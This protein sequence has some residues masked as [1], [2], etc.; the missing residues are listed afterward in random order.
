MSVHPSIRSPYRARV[1][2]T[3]GRYPGGPGPLG[4]RRRTRPGRAER[5]AET[6]EWAAASGGVPG[7]PPRAEP[8]RCGAARGGQGRGWASKQWALRAR[9]RKA[10]A[11]AQA[12]AGLGWAE[13][14]GSW[15]DDSGAAPARPPGARPTP[16]SP[17]SQ[18]TAPRPMARPARGFQAGL[19]GRA[20]V[21]ARDCPQECLGSG[22]QLRVCT[23]RLRASCRQEGREAADRTR[24]VSSPRG[25]GQRPRDRSR[26]EASPPK[27]SSRHQTRWSLRCRPAWRA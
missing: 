15:T 23:S 21:D 17:A 12:L 8:C 1:V 13:P 16:S 2:L 5:S 27:S 22:L 9:T 3:P 11:G 18:E 10:A 26:A 25:E 20:S 7:S 4:A 14:G 24:T 19:R 6:E